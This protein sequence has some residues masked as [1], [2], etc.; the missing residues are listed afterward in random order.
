MVMLL[1]IEQSKVDY[2]RQ[3]R[4]QGSEVSAAHMLCCGVTGGSTDSLVENHSAAM[5]QIREV[6]W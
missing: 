2:A 1:T 4:I 5:Q 3:S 6:Q